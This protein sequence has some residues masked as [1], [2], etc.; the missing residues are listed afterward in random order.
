MGIFEK[1]KLGLSKSSKNLSSGLNDLIFKKKVDENKLNELEDFLI[2]SDVG[3]EVASELKKKFSDTKI[4]PKND[5]KNQIF[6]IFSDHI[7]EIL[8]PLEKN[9]EDLNKNKPCVILIAGVNGVGKTTTIGKLGKILGQNNKK[10]VLGAADTFRAAAVSQLEV[11]AKK[12]NADVIKS[13]EGADPA[14]VAYKAFEHGK[15]NNFEYVLIDTAGRLQNKKN[16]MDEFKKIVKVLKKIDQNAPH[17]TFLIIDATTGQSAISQVEEFMKI[18]PITGIIMTKLDGTAK[19]GILLAIGRK[20][21][22]PIVALG[23]GEKEDD[24]Q[25][26]NSEYFSNALM[27]S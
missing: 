4:D 1:F 5:N 19:G 21:K 10:V 17:E 7:L 12:I 3:V 14:S 8:K 13:Q 25:K 27:H 23:M 15:N 2:Q 9:L 18:T 24:L 6:Q 16:L 20:F 26:F 11:W 22:L